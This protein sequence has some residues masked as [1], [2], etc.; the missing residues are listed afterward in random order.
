MTGIFAVYSFDSRWR[1]SKFLYYGLLTLVNRGQE[2]TGMYLYN[3]DVIEVERRGAVDEVYNADEVAK[4]SGWIGHGF[5]S[6]RALGVDS[7][8]TK[9][10]NVKVSMC[11]YGIS[12]Q[13][14]KIVFSSLCNH[15]ARHDVD[16][17]ADSLVDVAVKHNVP[18][19]FTALTSD[20]TMYVYRDPSGL[21]PMCVGSYGFE[22]AVISSESASIECVGADLRAYVRP[23]ELQI[24]RQ[25]SIERIKVCDESR[26]HCILEYVYYARPDSIIDGVPIYNIRYRLGEKL[27]E[28]F[29]VDADVVVGVPETG[30]PYAI[31]YSRRTGVE[32]HVGFVPVGKRVRAALTQDV[33]ERLI[34]VQ[35]KLMP[36]RSVFRGK[37]VIIVDDSVLKGVTLRNVVMSLRNRIGAKE[38]HVLI[39]CPRITHSCPFGMDIPDRSELITAALDEKSIAYAIGA[40]SV[41]FLSLD[42]V[43]E[44]F[45]EFGIRRDEVCTTCTTGQIVRLYR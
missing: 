35:L 43:L 32:Y 45:R 1:V 26:R 40:D 21:K 15:I 7:I 10:D 3:G 20:G 42:D 29:R 28:R 2:S 34:G 39:I 41:R 5:T 18:L 22:F 12:E 38:V 27:A 19:T 24:Y 13:L 4:M 17:I 30:I 11:M 33:L 6:S 9:I 31:A 44:V 23:G 25:G 8:T 14:S 37:R 36:V 16:K